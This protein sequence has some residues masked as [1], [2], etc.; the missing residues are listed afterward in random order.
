MFWEGAAWHM[1]YNASVA[2]LEDPNQPREALRVK[3]Q[4]EY[5][6][7]GEDYLLRGIQFNRDRAILYDR[8]GL[9]YYDKFKD[10]CRAAAAYTEAAKRA[11]AMPYCRRLAV[12]NL[13]LCPGHEQEAYTKLVELYNRGKD[14]RLPTLLKRLDELQDKLNIPPEKR[15]DTSEDWKELNRHGFYK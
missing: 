10:P 12:Y 3:A 9:L 13:A 11:D 5:F 4:R 8:L 14:E 7:I 6:K 15:I 2:A 1:A